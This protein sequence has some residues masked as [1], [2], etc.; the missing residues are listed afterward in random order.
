[1]VLNQCALDITLAVRSACL[2]QVLRVRA[3]DVDLPPRERGPH[4]Q[5]VESVL[6]DLL[7]PEPGDGVDD[8]AVTLFVEGH[9]RRQAQTKVIDPDA[10]TARWLEF[11]G[12]LIEDFDAHLAEDR[13]RSRQAHRLPAAIDLQPAISGIGTS[14]HSRIEL[15][16]QAVLNRQVAED[17]QIRHRGLGVEILLVRLRNRAAEGVTKTLRRH[18]VAVSRYCLEELFTPPAGDLGDL[19]FDRCALGLWRCLAWAHRDQQLHPYQAEVDDAV[20][21]VDDLARPV[22]ADHCFNAATRIRTEAL[23]REVHED[24]DEVAV[25]VSPRKDTDRPVIS[26]RDYELGQLEQVSG[27]RLEQLVPGQRAQRGEQPPSG[28]TVGTHSGAR[29]DFGEALSNHRH[30]RDGA[31][32]LAW[33]SVRGRHGSWACGWRH[34]WPPQKVG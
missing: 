14:G 3:Q 9:S 13:Q 7:A 22:P 4:N 20:V 6:F 19:G 32:C 33:R 27:G 10:G 29:Q 16:G 12:P 28:V 30:A 34:P 15:K 26:P 11:V 24:G 8:V 2:T 31:I 18:G 21:A 5:C 17:E 23:R 1:M 25:E